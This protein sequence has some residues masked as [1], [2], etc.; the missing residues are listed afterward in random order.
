[1]TKNYRMTKLNFL[2]VCNFHR[3][4]PYVHYVILSKLKEQNDRNLQNDKI[5]LRRQTLPLNPI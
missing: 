4:G 3:V 1:M 2:Y 5:Y